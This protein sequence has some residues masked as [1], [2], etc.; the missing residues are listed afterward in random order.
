MTTKRVTI[1]GSERAKLHGARLVGP[2]NPQERIEVTLLLSS[3]PP[4]PSPCHPW[5]GPAMSSLM[6]EPT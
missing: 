1:A 5:S 4:P 3:N 6:S 2:A